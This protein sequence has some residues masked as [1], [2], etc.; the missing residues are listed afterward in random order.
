MDH[1]RLD[2]QGEVVLERSLLIEQI[3]SLPILYFLLNRNPDGIVT[4]RFFDAFKVR[5]LVSFIVVHIA[6]NRFLLFRLGVPKLYP[7]MIMLRKM[8]ILIPL[9]MVSVLGIFRESM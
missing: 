8:P 2:L 7:H 1:Y 9:F 3:L 5:S 6:F 4:L